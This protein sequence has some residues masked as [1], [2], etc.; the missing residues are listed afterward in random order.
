MIRYTPPQLI[1]SLICATSVSSCFSCDHLRYHYVRRTL[2]YIR[3]PSPAPAAI[4]SLQRPQNK[5]DMSDYNERSGKEAQTETKQTRAWSRF[6]TE[7]QARA[8]SRF[9]TEGFCEELGRLFKRRDG[10]MQ[11]KWFLEN[12]EHHERMLGTS[13]RQLQQPQDSKGTIDQT[14]RRRKWRRSG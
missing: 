7:E 6:I 8:L 9:V 2:E 14:T 13:F 12:Y 5:D 4:T 1:F 10:R 11:L 3:E